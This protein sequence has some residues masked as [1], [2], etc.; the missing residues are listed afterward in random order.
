MGAFKVET[1]PALSMPMRGSKP[2]RR[3]SVT[4]R[5]AKTTAERPNSKQAEELMD[6]AVDAARSLHLPDFLKRFSARAAAMAGA[7]WGGVVVFEDTGAKLYNAVELEA[8][9]NAPRREWLLNKALEVSRDVVPP[10]GSRGEEE[11][12]RGQGCE[13]APS[14]GGGRARRQWIRESGQGTWHPCPMPW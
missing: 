9:Q 3:T 14:H 10:R 1:S 11:A 5:K 8:V 6:L 7:D 4:L 13:G 12:G 2:G